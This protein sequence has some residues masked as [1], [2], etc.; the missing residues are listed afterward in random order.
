MVGYKCR[1]LS[2]INGILKKLVDARSES[3]LPRMACFAFPMAIGSESCL[4][5]YSER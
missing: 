1:L 3:T 2:E 5:F 4:A